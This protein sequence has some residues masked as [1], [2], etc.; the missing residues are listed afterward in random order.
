MNGHYVTNVSDEVAMA[1]LRY[2]PKRLHMVLGRAVQNLLPPP[3][4]DSLQD[5]IIYKTPSG[6]MGEALQLASIKK[7]YIAKMISEIIK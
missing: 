7:I 1:I 3:P 2:S 6:Q 4:P 5:I